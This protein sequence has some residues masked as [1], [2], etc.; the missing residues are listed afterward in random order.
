MRNETD[1][2]ILMNSSLTRLLLC[3]SD[4]NFTLKSIEN[5][6]DCS[7]T[8]SFGH[9][10]RTMTPDLL[11]T[12][13]MFSIWAGLTGRETRNMTFTRAVFSLSLCFGVETRVNIIYSVFE[14]LRFHRLS[15]FIKGKKSI[16]DMQSINFTD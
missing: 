16:I 9:D 2:V 4:V 7:C 15:S 10:Q 5:N 1:F 12:T 11:F 6:V 3:H 8:R 13:S 14:C